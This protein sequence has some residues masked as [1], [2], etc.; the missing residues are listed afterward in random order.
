MVSI[1]QTDKQFGKILNQYGID[2]EEDP[3][4]FSLSQKDFKWGRTVKFS[5]D[6][7]AVRLNYY[8]STAKDFGLVQHE[9][10]HC[11]EFILDSI[12]MKLTYSSDEAYAYL[13]QYLT[14]KIYELLKFKTK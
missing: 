12:G 14:E 10:F 4:I 11:I 13:I 5:N 9:I 1:N 2:K 3:L 6:Q 7:T 8:P